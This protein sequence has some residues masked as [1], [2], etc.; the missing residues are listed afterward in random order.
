MSVA[1]MGDGKLLCVDS[2][3]NVRD[4]VAVAKSAIRKHDATVVVVDYAQLVRP[5]ERAENRNLEVAA[6]SR[7]LQQLAQKQNVAVVLLSQFNRAMTGREPCLA[8]LRD[9]GALEQDA[10]MAI[11]LSRD[12]RKAKGETRVEVLCNVAKNRNGPTPKVPLIMDMERMLFSGGQNL[13][14][15]QNAMFSDGSQDDDMRWD[16]P[17]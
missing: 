17:F 3:T 8:D 10:H 5:A 9:S 7:A 15:R 14:G 2:V 1:R 12:E 11:L 4:I 6:I 13:A 16:I